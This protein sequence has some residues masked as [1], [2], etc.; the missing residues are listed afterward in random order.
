MRGQFTLEALK[1]HPKVVPWKT[2]IEFG[3]D[4]GLPSVV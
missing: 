1:A 2:E 4:M 3:V